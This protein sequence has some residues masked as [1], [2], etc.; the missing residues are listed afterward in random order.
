M[1]GLDGSGIS[2]WLNYS[3]YFVVS[4]RCSFVW[5][6]YSSLH[7]VSWL[8]ATKYIGKLTKSVTSGWF[9][10]KFGSSFFATGRAYARLQNA[11]KSPSDA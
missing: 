10:D 9:L 11:S 3:G 5:S 7:D 2:G 1:C 6:M 4:P 8:E